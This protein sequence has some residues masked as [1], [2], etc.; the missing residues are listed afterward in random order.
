[1]IPSKSNMQTNNK[2]I[3]LA[4][5]ISLMVHGSLL[6]LFQLFPSFSYAQKEKVVNVLIPGERI[7][8]YISLGGSAP[9]ISPHPGPELHQKLQ[10]EP[11]KANVSKK[12]PKSQLSS[13]NQNS[14]L[15]LKNNEKPIPKVEEPQAP[16]ASNLS[17]STTAF[18]STNPSSSGGQGYGVGSG[19]GP[20]TGVSTGNTTQKTQDEMQKYI[21]K[22]IRILDAKKYYPRL[23]KENG[24]QG[25]IMV[26][27]VL[28]T[29][30]ELLDYQFIKKSDYER[31]NNATVET[32]KVASPFPPVPASYTEA[33]LVV[34]VPVSFRM[35][36]N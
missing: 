3:F 7:A 4:I 32:L 36:R 14:A 28:S 21:V 20:G 5:F 27:L 17:E 15:T 9:S 25:T 35:S 1:M 13:K 30:G 34:E 19:D 24:E 2:K 10:A 29:R 31:L 12:T 6:L 18:A 11:V 16:S 26:K 33:R 22:I 23:S 8:T